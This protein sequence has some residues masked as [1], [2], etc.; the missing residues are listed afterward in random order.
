MDK[1]IKVK[2]VQEPLFKRLISNP[3]KYYARMC[4]ITFCLVG[5][6]NFLTT[7]CDFGNNNNDNSRR[8][9]LFDH[10]QLYFIMLLSKSGYFSLLWP[11]FYIT[12]IREPKNAFVLG[13]GLKKIIEENG[14]DN[15]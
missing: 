10:P 15:N 12:A 7:L 13:A 4:G 2:I 9:F 11:S 3:F 14:T 1:I 6:S 8:T 5:T